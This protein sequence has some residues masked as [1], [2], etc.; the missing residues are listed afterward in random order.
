MPDSSYEFNKWQLLIL[1]DAVEVKERQFTVSQDRKNMVGG[2]FP[3]MFRAQNL[4]QGR[5]QEVRLGDWVK[6]VKGLRSTDW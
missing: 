1:Q 2:N 4:W 5:G 3:N 6:K